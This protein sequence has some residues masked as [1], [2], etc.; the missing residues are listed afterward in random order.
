MKAKTL[1]KDFLSWYDK[2]IV[3]A[4]LQ[5]KEE[6]YDWV[7]KSINYNKELTIKD[8]QD[9]FDRQD[10]NSEYKS[11]Y[12]ETSLPSKKPYGW[13]QVE[14]SLIYSFHKCFAMRNQTRLQHYRHDLA[15]KGKRTLY[16]ARVALGKFE[17]L[18]DKSEEK[19]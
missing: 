14:I 15:Q 16:A 12:L 4:R 18:K 5:N 19:I 11:R 8:Y 7:Y 10:L 2:V 1:F 13:F 3:P 6:G 9:F 17:H